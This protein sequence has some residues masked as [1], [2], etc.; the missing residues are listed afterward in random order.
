M[1]KII[2][3]FIILFLASTNIVFAQT[4]DTTDID[5]NKKQIKKFKGFIDEDGNGID[6]RME[7]MMLDQKGHHKGMMDY[8]I[9]EDGDGINDNRCSGIGMMKGKRKQYRGKK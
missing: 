1:N 4:S 3:I 6:D 8:F 5:I 9:D 7:K 2:Y